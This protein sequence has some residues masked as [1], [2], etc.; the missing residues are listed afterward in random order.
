MS[1]TLFKRRNILSKSKIVHE[2]GSKPIPS[3]ISDVRGRGQAHRKGSGTPRTSVPSRYSSPNTETT[4]PLYTGIMMILRREIFCICRAS[5]RSSDRCR[6]SMI[7]KMLSRESWMLRR[8]V[9]T[10]AC[11]KGWRRSLMDFDENR[12][13]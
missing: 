10:G 12:R 13:G 4:A 7:R 1:L 8:D 11:L 3:S 5:S 2:N 9:E 6:S